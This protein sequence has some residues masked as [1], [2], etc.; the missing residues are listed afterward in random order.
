MV[1][2]RFSEPQMVKILRSLIAP[3]ALLGKHPLQQ[4]PS[5]EAASL[6]KWFELLYSRLR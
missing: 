3:R 2:T 6:P 1:K 5:R 4:P